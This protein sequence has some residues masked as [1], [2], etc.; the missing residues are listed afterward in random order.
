MLRDAEN[1]LTRD[2]F[3]EQPGQEQDVLRS[4]G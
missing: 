1:N 3:K 2:G 4:L